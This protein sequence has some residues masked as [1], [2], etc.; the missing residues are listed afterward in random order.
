MMLSMISSLPLQSR[1]AFGQTLKVA[2]TI[3]VPPPEA[4]PPPP[5]QGLTGQQVQLV[6]TVAVLGGLLS[7]IAWACK[8]PGKSK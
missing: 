1:I 2:Q 6:G 7:G 4:P 5:S 3:A 8:N